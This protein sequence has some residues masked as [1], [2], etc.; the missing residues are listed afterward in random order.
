MARPAWV[1]R[2]PPATAP[3]GGRHGTAAGPRV[4]RRVLA[5]CG[6]VLLAAVAAVAAVAFVTLG[7]GHG[8]PG[9]APANDGQAQTAASGGGQN[10]LGPGATAPGQPAVTARGAGAPQVSFSWT[11]ANP[12]AGDT[13]RWQRVSGS[14]RSPGGT[15]AGRK[16][17]MSLPPATASASWSRSAGQ[18]AR[19]LTRPS[20]LWPS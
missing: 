6:G 7:P 1:G 10:A 3:P 14:G 5:V 20:P 2:W 19:P 17:V 12:V 13:F 16:L 18:A 9:G 8:R 4:S 11:Y 15:V